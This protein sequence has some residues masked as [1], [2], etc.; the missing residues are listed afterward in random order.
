MALAV[1]LVAPIRFRLR[2]PHNVSSLCAASSHNLM[3]AAPPLAV[4]IQFLFHV[5]NER[6][7]NNVC[8]AFEIVGCLESGKLRLK[9]IAEVESETLSLST[10]HAKTISYLLRVYTDTCYA[11]GIKSLLTQA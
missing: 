4:G 1:A 6:F 10:F 7:T 5:C 8:L 3:E 11:P 2:K 9:P